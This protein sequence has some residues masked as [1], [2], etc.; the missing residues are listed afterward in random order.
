MSV[1]RSQERAEL[2]NPFSAHQQGR[3]A[4]LCADR[5]RDAVARLYQVKSSDV[6]FTSGAAEANMI[7]VRTAVLCALRCGAEPEELHIVI[8]SEEHSS[9]RKVISYLAAFGISHTVIIPEEGRRFSPEEV[10]RCVRKNTVCLSLQYVNS[11][12]GAVQPLAR[13]A[14]ACREVQPGLFVHTDAAQATAWRTCSP[15][16][17]RADAVSVDGAKAFGPQG[18]GALLFAHAERYAGLE[19]K[20]ETADMRPGTPS[21]ALLCGFAA[22]LENVHLHRERYTRSVRRARDLAVDLLRDRFPDAYVH[23][24]EKTIDRTR[25]K[26][27]DDCAPHLLYLTFSGTNHLYL[28]TLLDRD[29]FSV[30]T[31]SACTE[32][33][34]DALRIGFL[35]TTSPGDVRAF[36][37][38]VEKHIAL[39]K[40]VY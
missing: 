32:Q 9:V 20:H 16:A 29:G 35:P 37:R 39:A 23:G 40:R 31:S 34:E 11:V 17:L 4:Q 10:A 6:L 5:S 13:I 38:C 19:G 36:V 22:A 15:S 12:H 3:E 33:S 28:S 1:L 8:G 27:F 30:S 7:A 26:D 24:V 21:V 18:T 14:D 2:G 25:P